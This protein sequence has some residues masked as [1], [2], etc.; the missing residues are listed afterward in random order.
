MLLQDYENITTDH[1][2][3]KQSFL[4]LLSSFQDFMADQSS[5]RS[6]KEMLECS[7]ENLNSSNLKVQNAIQK[8][9]DILKHANKLAT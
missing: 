7:L 1:K 3:L 5:K 8:S 4:H 6:A 2:H 9:E